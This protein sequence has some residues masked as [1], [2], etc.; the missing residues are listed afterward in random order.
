MD[1]IKKSRAVIRTSFTRIYNSIIDALV[2]KDP[3]MTE[4]QA[5]LGLL[6]TKIEALREF[7]QQIFNE[8]L[9]SENTS[10]AV[11]DTEMSTADEY[12]SKYNKI[13][14]TIE[15]R[16]VKDVNEEICSRKS[17]N[18][19][20]V[21]DNFK[22]KFKL[23][24][25]EFQRFSGEI[26]EWLPFWSQ[27]K[28]IHEDADIENEDKFQYLLQAT[29]PKSRARQLVESYPCT[30]DNYMKVI[31]SL[32]SRFGRDDLLVEVYV[33]ELLKL[34]LSNLNDKMSLATLY[35]KMEAQLRALETL[36][37][38]SDKYTA[39]LYPLVESCLPEELLRI[40]QRSS[41]YE[42]DSVLESRLE[43]MMT[44]LRN[45]VENEERIS[46]AVTGFNLQVNDKFKKKKDTSLRDPIYKDVATASGLIN[47]KTQIVKCVF[48]NA[49]HF[50]KDCIEAQ[51]LS[52]PEKTKILRKHGCCFSCAKYGHLTK[53]CRMNLSC[54]KCQSKHI[55]LMCPKV[56]DKSEVLS[57]V[58][59]ATTAVCEST[60]S[61][62]TYAE[63]FLQ[64]LVV[65]LRGENTERCVRAIIDT[66]SQKSY[67]TEAAA[68]EMEYLPI[69]EENMIHSLF[70]GG[71]TAICSH[72]C[73]RIRLANFD[74]SYACNFEALDQ[75]IICKNI[76]C[77]KEGPWLPEIQQ[78]GIQITDKIEG[79]I[80]VLIGADVAGKLL[81]GRRHLLTCNLVA[82]ETLL[83]WTLIGKAP[84]QST[85]K[86]TSTMIV[87]SMF[88][89]DLDVSQLWSLDILGI[90]D[91]GERKLKKEMELATMQHFLKTLYV[92]SEG[93]YE[94]TM[95][96]I[97]GHAPV[98][99]NLKVARTRLDS[100]VNKLNKD[101][102]YEEYCQVLYEWLAEG[103]IE[104][105]P[106]SELQN[107]SH[108]LPHRHVVK[109]S[110]ATTKVR[111]VFDA[112]A[113]EKGFPSLNQ[114][115]EKGINLI[116]LVPSILIRFRLSKIGVVSDIRKAFLQISLCSTDRDFL[117]FLWYEKGQMKVYR[118]T[119]VVFGVTCS[120]FLLGAVIAY[121][122]HKILRDNENDKL[123]KYSDAVILKLMK[124]FYVDNC[125]TSVNSNEELNQFIHEAST[126]MSEA[127]FDLRGW[128]HTMLEDTDEKISLTPVLGLYWD[129][130]Y[131]YLELSP[132]CFK[133]TNLDNNMI[134]KRTILSVV[135]SVF[136]PIGFTCP[137]LLCPKL[138]L[139]RTWTT[140]I[141]WD[142]EV[143]EDMKIKF[144]QWT[145]ELHRLSDLKIPRWLAKES[146]EFSSWSL[147]CF[148]DA[149][150][151]AYATAI[152]LRSESRQSVNIQLIQAKARISPVKKMT[153]PR[154]EMLAATIGARLTAT[155][156]EVLEKDI[157]TFYWTDSTT[158]LS[159]IRRDDQWGPFI[160]NRVQEIRNLTKK[161][162]WYHVPGIMN[163]AD[164]P[165]RGC[166]AKHL[167]E[168]RWWEGPEWLRRPID[169][170]P[171]QN[172]ACDDEIVN[173]EKRKGVVSSLLSVEINFNWYY[174]YFS[175]YSKIIRLLGWIKRF[176]LNCRQPLSRNKGELTME[177]LNNAEICIIKLIQQ[178]SFHGVTDK[179]L[180]SLRPFIDGNGLIRLK[181]K[182]SERSDQKEFRYPAVLPQ[183]HPVVTRLIYHQHY[184]ACHVGVQG[185][186]SLLRERF[187]ILSGR[188]TV[189][190]VVSQCTICRRYNAKSLETFPVSLPEHRVR[191]AAVFE[192]TGVD[193]A[194]PIFLRGKQKTW[195]CLFTCAIYR[196]VHLELVPSLSTDAFLQAFRRFIARRGRPII[197]CSDNGTNFVGAENAFNN[198]DWNK[199]SEYSSV[200]RIT[201]KF[202][203]PSAAWWGGW[204]ERLIRL[205]KQ[206]LRRVLGR[207]SLSYEEMYTVLC[208]CESVINSRPL[209]YLSED[210]TDLI[211][212]TPAMFLQDIKEVGVPDIDKV[213]SAD[214]SKRWIYRQK[215]RE[216]LRSRF[217]N[218]YLGQLT[219]QTKKRYLRR[220][221]VGEVVL[222]GSDNVKR[223]DWPLARVE[224]LLPGQDGE[225]RVVRLK[226]SLGQVMRPL[227]RIYPLE[228]SSPNSIDSNVEQSKATY[229]TDSEVLDKIPGENNDNRVTV[230]RVGRRV[231]FPNRY[232]L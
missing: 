90:T 187:W 66:G 213:E 121:H 212:L 157:P 21:C 82:V 160:W 18:G 193:F 94:V 226:T 109:L 133:N 135:H 76:S 172:Y 31:E 219:Q 150:Q 51:K 45:E 188:R 206:L 127:K 11:F 178:E 169:Q 164:L 184:K 96:W 59:N 166:S 40:W 57:Q 126:L 88:S 120:P 39:M 56:Q 200:E 173:R 119:R 14:I 35:D 125:V 152:F 190:S 78:L 224:E 154:L 183:K 117:R 201:W 162:T 93:R 208:D 131:D 77:I 3:D 185:L 20:S 4:V 220:I 179:R 116:E 79:P 98:P 159:W 182:I 49:A 175:K 2:T 149:S 232:L 142:E 27:F 101:G 17:E 64:T 170:W 211:A 8:L 230:T 15:Q 221:Q 153:I 195:I 42:K 81:T 165:S 10:D 102:Y 43:S 163:P 171:D 138:L 74:N 196:A 73:Y 132:T 136:D 129:R 214:M 9:E 218:E 95:P 167:I 147:H 58:N 68:T 227:Q 158:V 180:V 228:M 198:L 192:I 34:V 104:A 100:L 32:K 12:I 97:E 70:G 174:M 54:P 222:I 53:N 181:T 83:G 71:Q 24:V 67:I 60:L 141:S 86:T 115:L 151:E 203:P 105:V 176:I 205:I 84:T 26:K 33:R 204:W 112:S 63:V 75:P 225:V 209:T 144:I 137:V 106:D 44:F 92:N 113:K 61:N 89:K 1:R 217:R 72:K 41:S 194:G 210:S 30:S 36:G 199:I 229:T 168:S 140:K 148:C 47:Y 110:S 161:E 143:P 215:L 197:M 22:K 46:L 186:L 55:V 107:E 155:V 69:R 124:S 80:E 99:S 123:S 118:H 207:A 189:R 37:V 223:L 114:C 202:N 25:I 156:I 19:H 139:Q 48:C 52:L 103:I 216:N 111:P 50:N 130:K 29:I 7:D 23:P 65:K 146:V 38:T 145:S 28:R 5:N 191:D 134:T 177:E 122:L 13:K 87:T 128:E 16:L 108:Y 231:R 85:T 6:D 62:N 91:P